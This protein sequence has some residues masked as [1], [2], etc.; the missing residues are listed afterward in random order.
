MYYPQYRSPPKIVMQTRIEHPCVNS[1]GY[2]TLDVLNVLQIKKKNFRPPSNSLSKYQ[3]WFPGYTTLS[4]LILLEGVCTVIF[5]IFDC[6]YRN[7]NATSN[8]EQMLRLKCSLFNHIWYLERAII[9][10]TKIL[11]FRMK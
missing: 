1:S 9:L 4:I 2:I 11:H 7:G 6:L 3:Y 5:G 8:F 10:A